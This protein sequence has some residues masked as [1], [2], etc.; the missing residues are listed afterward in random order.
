MNS[1]D[2]SEEIG[3]VE[4]F[5]FNPESEKCE[6]FEWKGWSENE[7]NFPS[8]PECQIA[9]DPSSINVTKPLRCYQKF[10]K[11]GDGLVM[12]LALFRKWSYDLESSECKS[13]DY[14]GCGGNENSFDTH[15]EC[16]LTCN[17]PV[18]HQTDPIIALLHYF[19]K[20]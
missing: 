20:N 17:H 2:S 10:A 3:S 4:R 7:N 1:T 12:C 13:F 5:F 16:D 11:N 6:S 19:S 15:E 14:C 9:C 8:K 18:D